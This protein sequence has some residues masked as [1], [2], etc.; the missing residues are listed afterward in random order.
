MMTE[1]TQRGAANR[2]RRRHAAAGARWTVGGLA[3]GAGLGM[4]GAMGAAASSTVEAP[5]EARRIIH[6][7]VVADAPGEA[8]DA[9]VNVIT[10]PPPPPEVIT[11]VVELPAPAPPAA[12]PQ[13]TSGGS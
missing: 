5:P 11:R 1:A 3:L 9:P 7:V 4:I 12:E 10:R 6:R 8:L 13:A 2:P